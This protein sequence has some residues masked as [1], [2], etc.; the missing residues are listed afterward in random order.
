MR[1]QEDEK[2]IRKRVRKMRD[3]YTHLVVYLVINTML[4]FIWYFTSGGF[5][6]FVFPLGGW[7]IGLF[8]H[9]YSVFIE[10]GL[11]GKDWEDRKVKKLM[12]K[13]KGRKKK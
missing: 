9:W 12:E 13:E 7:G 11:M 10:D 5:P 4:V 1:E 6:W 3:F 8:F 2:R